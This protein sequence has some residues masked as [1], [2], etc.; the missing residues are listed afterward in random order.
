MKTVILFRH[1]KSDWRAGF[2]ADHDRPLSKRGR[3]AAS[4]MGR[5]L[6]EIDQ[7]PD[8]L[9]CSSAV[10][11][12][13]TLELAHETGKWI[14]QIHVTRKLYEALPEDVL[15]QIRE[16]PQDAES[17]ILVGHEPTCSETV[18]RLVGGGTFR[19]PT[20]AMARIDLGVSEWTD[21]RFGIGQLIWFLPPR[22]LS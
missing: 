3:K 7:V 20:A 18:S 14:G 6:S 2:D 4:A 1:A 5:W 11:A 12:H 19:F 16:A 10:R 21:A 22:V 13:T 8:H 15:M 9:V 17:V